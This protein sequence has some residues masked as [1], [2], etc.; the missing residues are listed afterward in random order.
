[1]TKKKQKVKFGCLLLAVL[2]AT[3]CSK[4]EVAEKEPRP[5]VIKEK[6]I[7]PN[8]P[9]NRRVDF[10]TL[11]AANEDVYAWISVPD[12]NVDYPIYQ[13][14]PDMEEDYYLLHKPDGTY[15]EAGSLYT[16]KE[17]AR[18]F[19]DPVT[20]VY[21]HTAFAPGYEPMFSELHKLED[22]DFFQAHPNFYVYTEAGKGLRYEVFAVTEFDDRLILGSEDFS[23]PAKLKDLIAE[24][25]QSAGERVRPVE[26]DDPDVLILSTCVGVGSSRRFLVGA[27]LVE[28]T[29]T[30]SKM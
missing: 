10:E 19:S 12:T 22:L 1:M 16:Q 13:S 21:G 4:T 30:P 8:D 27:R 20:V 3:G 17:N 18:D 5:P 9:V 24:M 29:D 11:N 15:D 28:Q 25:Q 2:A 23:D 7:D 14:D 26:E 6:K